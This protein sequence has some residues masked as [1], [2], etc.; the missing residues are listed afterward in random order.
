[1]RKEVPVFVRCEGWTGVRR[2]FTEDLAVSGMALL[3]SEPTAPGTRMRLAVSCGPG[4]RA[5]VEGQVC[6]C[7]PVNV[8]VGATWRIGIRLHMGTA[9]RAA[10]DSLLKNR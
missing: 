3:A 10:L 9:E 4:P 1:V 8:E 7:V 2:L 6:Y 5:R